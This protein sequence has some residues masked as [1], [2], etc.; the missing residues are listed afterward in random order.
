MNRTVIVVDSRT[1]FCSHAI[2][3]LPSCKIR[4]M[5]HAA[6]TNE[7]QLGTIIISLTPR[8]GNFCISAVDN[9]Y[10]AGLLSYIQFFIISCLSWWP[11]RFQ[12]FHEIWAESPVG[13]FVK[14]DCPSAG[15]PI[16]SL[17]AWLEMMK[18][19]KGDGEMLAELEKDVNDLK[20]Y[21]KILQ[22]WFKTRTGKR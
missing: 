4:G 15:T 14:R 1:R 20:R 2:W 11:I 16:S 18:I 10:P 6:E 17:M 7:R 5:W 9:P 12:Y 22:N 21:G 3:T 13:W 8:K 19:R